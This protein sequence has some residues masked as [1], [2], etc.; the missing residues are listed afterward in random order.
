MTHAEVLTRATKRFGRK[1]AVDQMD[2]SVRRGSVTGFLGP[3]GSGKTTT[4]RLITRLYEPE[5][6]TVE[7]LGSVREKCASDRVGYLPEERGLYR[8]MKVLEL[9]CFFARLKG[10]RSPEASVREWLGRLDLAEA[11]GLK[12]EALSKGMAQRVQFIGAVAHRPEL[13]ILDEPFSGLDPVHAAQISDAI[14]ELKAAG[15][16][17]ILSTHDM[18]VA[19]RM[20]D[21]LVLIHEGRKVLDGTWA[22]VRS[23]HG[24]VTVRARLADGPID[25]SR[26]PGVERCADLGA[27]T[28]IV[29]E[30]GVDSQELLRALQQQGPITRFDLG[31]STLR[32]IFLDLVGATRMEEAAA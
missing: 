29:L 27:E 31:E 19:E 25:T 9:L 15:S 17:V 32:E 1:V 14:R 11:A 4:L 8:S 28:A 3:N 30:P 26:L 10:V 12:V 2:L 23:R 20:C 21:S 22:E 24:R 16:T 13:V 18:D 5:E 7:V 6:G